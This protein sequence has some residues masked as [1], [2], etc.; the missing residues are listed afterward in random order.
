MLRDKKGRFCKRQDTETPELPF[1]DER[2]GQIGYH[3][4]FEHDLKVNRM[5]PRAEYIAAIEDGKPVCFPYVTSPNFA[6]TL[7]TDFEEAKS[8]AAIETAKIKKETMRHIEQLL[9]D[10][11]C[12]HKHDFKFPEAFTL[13]KWHIGDPVY[14]VMIRWEFYQ[15]VAVFKGRVIGVEWDSDADH[16]RPGWRYRVYYKRK[17][18][19]LDV[20]YG[21]KKGS[22]VEDTDYVHDYDMFHDASLAT[23]ALANHAVLVHQQY[24]EHSK[25]LVSLKKEDVK[26]EEDDKWHKLNL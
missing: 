9:A 5:S 17:A 6:V 10:L 2:I 21:A 13:P 3:T 25:F 23:A 7:T 18:N 24:E 20:E 12:P 26:P 8:K 19:K 22:M 11:G 16:G 14:V 1:T 4:G 15:Q